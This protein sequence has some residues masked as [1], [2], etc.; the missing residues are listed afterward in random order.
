M[1]IPVSIYTEGGGVWY[2]EATLLEHDADLDAAL[3]RLDTSKRI[4]FGAKLPTR[5][6]LEG[7]RIFD[8]IYAV[9]CPLGNDPIPT[10]GEIADTH[11]HVD[12]N[13]YWMINAPTYIGNSGGGIFDAQS[14]ALL[15]IF[16]KIYTHGSLRPTVVPHMGLVTPL[17]RIY[18]WLES[19]GYAE[20]ITI[21]SDRGEKLALVH[22]EGTNGESGARH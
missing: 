11:H 1:P 22:S 12:G 4:R 8:K 6:Q 2:E 18:D 5:D 7:I 10:P 17:E 16:S 19:E 9:G 20:L 14:G 3:L 15:G 21:D 13:A